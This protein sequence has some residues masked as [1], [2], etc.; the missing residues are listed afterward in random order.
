VV[1]KIIEESA[2]RPFDFCARYGG[3]EFALFIYGQARDHRDVLPEQIREAIVAAKIPHSGSDLGI[4]TVSIGAAFLEPDTNRSMRGLIQSAD[5]A[6][7]QAKNL[8]RNQVVY[9]NAGEYPAITGSFRAPA[10]KQR[11]A[12]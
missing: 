6:L 1:A 3:E 2:S 10:E 8:G 7:Y 9:K 5:E 12:C 4:V 11:Q